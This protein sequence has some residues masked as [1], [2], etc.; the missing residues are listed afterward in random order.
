VSDANSAR[1]LW[2]RKF[3]VEAYYFNENRQLNT[4]VA[5]SSTGDALDELIDDAIRGRT[6]RAEVSD[7]NFFEILELM[8]PALE[9][10]APPGAGPYRLEL[11]FSRETEIML[12]TDF[13]LSA[14]NGKEGRD[15]DTAVGEP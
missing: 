11:T 9:K 3:W 4:K 8:K 10:C 7:A 13:R 5:L 6:R 1:Y 14:V 15:V 2:L 12:L